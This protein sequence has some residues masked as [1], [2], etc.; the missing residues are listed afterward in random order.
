MDRHAQQSDIAFQK[1][2]VNVA[3]NILLAAVAVSLLTLLMVWS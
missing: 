2:L 1:R 3:I